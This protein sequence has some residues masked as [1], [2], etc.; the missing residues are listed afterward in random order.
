MLQKSK[1]MR[2]FAIGAFA[3]TLISAP[4]ITTANADSDHRGNKHGGWVEKNERSGHD[5][6]RYRYGHKRHDH[7]YHRKHA[8][9]HRRLR[10]ARKHAHHY[11][12]RRPHKTV[13]KVIQAE[14]PPVRR[15]VS[16]ERFIASLIEAV[17]AATV[18]NHYR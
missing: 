9:K 6:E 2:A 17:V 18:A 3:V 10:H 13:Y 14:R 12:H 4:F 16:E 5:Q 8:R 11:D 1:I 15:R 7:K